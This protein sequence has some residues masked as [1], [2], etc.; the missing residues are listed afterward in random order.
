MLAILPLLSLALASDGHALLCAEL[1]RPKPDAAKVASLATTG[2]PAVTCRFEDQVLRRDRASGE[3]VIL[4]IVTGGLGFFFGDPWARYHETT[5]VTEIVPLELALLTR[6]P[7]LVRALVAAGVPVND[8]LSLHT[9]PL[10]LAIA[11]GR[12]KN[13]YTLART[14]LE[15]GGSPASLDGMFFGDAS[16]WLFTGPL[17]GE[18]RARG[19]SPSL[20]DNMGRSVLVDAIEAGDTALAAALLDAGADPN[21]ATFDTPL[22][23]AV[24]RGDADLVRRLLAAGADPRAG[25]DPPLTIAVTTGRLDLAD[26]LVAAGADPKARLPWDT[27]LL[28][29]AAKADRPDA[30]AW[31]L[32]HGVAVDDRS[33][34]EGTALARAASAGA[35]HAIR[36]LLDRGADPLLAPGTYDPTPVEVA[37]KAGQI[38]ALDLLLAHVPAPAPAV[39]PAAIEAG[40]VAVVEHLL[41]RGE[42][43]PADAMGIA[44]RGAEWAMVDWLL[45]RGT[46][47]D[48]PDR[49]GHT[50]L[51]G[52]VTDGAEE[53]AAELLKRGASL[54]RAGGADLLVRAAVDDRPRMLAWLSG[55][56]LQPDTRT[57]AAAVR[58]DSDDAFRWL[59]DHGVD[60][61][62]H[63]RG[64]G[65][66]L[67]AAIGEERSGLLDAILAA[68]VDP[69]IADA[70]GRTALGL[71]I[72][73]DDR[74]IVEKLLKSGAS[75]SV[76]DSGSSILRRAIAEGHIW[77]AGP[78]L[79]A[80][81]TTDA[82]IRVPIDAPWLVDDLEAAGLPF[83]IDGTL[84]DAVALGNVGMAE[85]LVARG[86]ALGP[87]HLLLAVR[88]HRLDALPWLFARIGVPRGPG[89]A[90]L[91]R[92][93]RRAGHRDAVRAAMRNAERDAPPE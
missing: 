82:P 30:V 1:R 31:V 16:L 85:K 66:V 12:E 58:A 67:H 89:R 19:L 2:E 87:E 41:A 33:F 80:G 23:L 10:S 39:L 38:A 75:P 28:F 61:R 22:T 3:W 36:V 5:Q 81:A 51:A 45:R 62:R 56:G 40:Q 32:D 52:A 25:S 20:K 48:A 26:A 49:W 77:A 91:L 83:W 17:A 34:H 4:G 43:L 7:E 44:A 37:A 35:V 86:A 54:D 72:D 13:D 90:A 15:L 47:I 50:A 70:R 74:A 69:A 42:P 93:A 24:K 53:R 76:T 63:V 60:P 6:R 78:L 64:G 59:I 65:T 79:E 57:L 9:T 88:N 68:G 55:Q 21:H 14:V 71:A 8:A 92:E 29:A 18:L 27:T 73:C 84:D 11:L 46:S